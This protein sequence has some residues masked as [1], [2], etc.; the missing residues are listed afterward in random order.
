MVDVLCPKCGC[1]EVVV[2]DDGTCECQG[3]G[4]VGSLDAFI[5]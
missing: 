4:F 3:F 2:Y 5:N 1:L